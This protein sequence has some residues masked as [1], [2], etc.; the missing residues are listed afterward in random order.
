MEN[1]MKQVERIYQ[2]HEEMPYISPN[3]DLA[4]W[5]E[6]AALSS[7]KLVPKRNM[8]RLT[9]GV[10]PGDIIILWRVQFGTY[11]NETVIS[12]YFEYLYGIDARAAI[13]DLQQQGYV[14]QLSAHESL[15]QITAPLLRKILKEKGIA[16]LAKLKKPELEALIHEKVSEEELGAY[17]T[18]RQ[19]VLTPSGEQLLANHPEVIAK[20]P[21]KKF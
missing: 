6:E 13:Q 17:F 18:V 5:L 4:T 9:E 3:R 12:K 19:Y 2:A 15:N 7:S 14:V 20:H 10:L 1:L 21:Q 11:T 16:N 8:I